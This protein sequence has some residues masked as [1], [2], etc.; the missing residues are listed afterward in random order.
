MN[1]VR[2]WF[3]NQ[4]VLNLWFMAASVSKMLS[5][6][7]TFLAIPWNFVFCCEGGRLQKRRMLPCEGFATT[8]ELVELPLESAD[9]ICHILGQVD[10]NTLGKSWIGM[11]WDVKK[12]HRPRHINGPQES[13]SC[14]RNDNC[15][16]KERSPVTVSGNMFNS[17]KK[18]WALWPVFRTHVD[19]GMFGSWSRCKH[20]ADA[21]L[22]FQRLLSEAVA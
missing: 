11:I 22:L 7:P 10:T 8:S 20:A 2:L 15:G 12:L 21:A 6:W 19:G 18:G 16:E 17:G 9:L 1:P 13:F 4:L 14:R 5:N 3:S